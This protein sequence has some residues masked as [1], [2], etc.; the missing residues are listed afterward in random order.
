[1]TASFASSPV[2][3]QAR[4]HLDLLGPLVDLIQR[5][6]SSVVPQGEVGVGKTHLATKLL[7]VARTK[8]ERLPSSVEGALRSRTTGRTLGYSLARQLLPTRSGLPFV[9][10][11][12]RRIVVPPTALERWT[13]APPKVIRTQTNQW[14]D[15]EPRP[16]VSQT[17]RPLERRDGI[18]FNPQERE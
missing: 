14:R 2:Q 4:T 5:G 15:I 17:Q 12:G 10:L 8:G 16:A 18:V 11:G 3:G 9:R 13:S 7:D 6:G 1:M